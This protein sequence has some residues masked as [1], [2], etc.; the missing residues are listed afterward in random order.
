[1]SPQWLPQNIQKR[2]LL[3]VLQQLSLF[4]EIDLPNLEEVSLNNIHLKDIS[5]DPEK[6]G[7]LP[8]CNLRYGQLGS[9]E[10]NGGVMGGV[11]IEV[12]NLDIVIAPNLDINE[13]ITKSV[14]LSLAQSTA[15]L[16]QTIMLNQSEVL[17]MGSLE[18]TIELQDPTCI[19]PDVAIDTS[20]SDSSKS[21]ASSASSPTIPKPSALGGVMARAVDMALSRLQVSIK[22]VNIKL[23]SELTDIV[24]KVE[25]ATLS[26]VSGT[27]TTHLKGVSVIT[28]RPACSPGDCEASNNESKDSTSGTKEEDSDTSSDDDNDE[29]DSS[30][31]DSMVFTHEEASSIYMSATSQSF[32][33]D[34]TEA[35]PTLCD[36]D[37][38]KSDNVIMY[39]DSLDVEF[40]GLSS[41]S[42]VFVEIEKLTLSCSPLVPT[43][44]SVINGISRSLK[45]KIYQK[46]KSTTSTYQ[47]NPRFPQYASQSDDINETYDKDFEDED[48]KHNGPDS[49]T[50]GD[51]QQ[52]FN[53]LH[54]GE[55]ILSVTSALN[56][57]GEFL[58]PNNNLYLSVQ[59][60]NIKQKHD[61]LIYGGLETFQIIKTTDGKAENVLEFEQSVSEDGEPPKADIRF[62]MFSKISSDFK[63]NEFTALISKPGKV[64]LDSYSLGHIS[65]LVDSFQIINSHLT[66]LFANYENYKRLSNNDIKP[67]VKKNKIDNHLVLQTAHMT[68]HL[69]LSSDCRI[70]VQILPIFVNSLNNE[71]K[72][73]RVIVEHHRDGG[74]DKIASISNIFLSTKAQDFK[75]FISH[76]HLFSR[77][78]NVISSTNVRVSKINVDLSFTLLKHIILSFGTFNGNLKS[79]PKRYNLVSMNSGS[80]YN[81]K[82]LKKRVNVTT[83]STKNT[84]EFNVTFEEANFSLNEINKQFGSLLGRAVNISLFEFNGEHNFVLKGVKLN[85]VSGDLNEKIFY[86]Y[87]ERS[88]TDISEPLVLGQLKKNG[89]TELK[90]QRFVI[91]FYAHWQK[92]FEN[93]NEEIKDDLNTFTKD[94]TEELKKTDVRIQLKDCF[95]GV[96]PNTLICKSY[97][98][99]SRVNC[100]LMLG[101]E[102]L[103][104][105]TTVRELSLLLIDDLKELRSVSINKKYRYS[106]NPLDFFLKRGFLNIGNIANLHIGITYNFNIEKLLE[107]SSNKNIYNKLSALDI[108]VNLDECILETCGD[109]FYTFIQLINDLKIPLVL[110]NEEKFKVNLEHEIN[111]LEG[112]D[113]L[114]RPNPSKIDS[115]IEDQHTDNDKDFEI[116]IDNLSVDNN[117]FS[118]NKSSQKQTVD[119]V[120]ISVNVGKANLYMYDGYD[121]KE[122]RKVI[123]GVVKKVEKE[124]SEA[125]EDHDSNDETVDDHLEII[126]ETLFQSIH[127]TLPKGIDPSQLTQN[128]NKQVTENADDGNTDGTGYKNLKLKRS[129]RYKM[130]IELKSIDVIVNVFTLRSP[131]EEPIPVHK[132]YEVLNEIELVVDLVTIYDNLLNSTWNKYLSYMNSIGEKEIGKN[133]IKFNLTTIRD[134]VSLNFNESILRI[135][136]LPLRLFIDQDTNEFLVRFFN[137]NDKRFKLE[138]L[139]EDIYVKKIEIRNDIKI[140]VDYKPKKLNL[141]GLKNGEFNELLNLIHINGLT[142]NLNHIKLYGIKGGDQ[143]FARLF[144]YW[145]P[146]IQQTQLVNL[147]N[148]VEIFKPFFSISESLK[149]VVLLPITDYHDLNN[150]KFLKKLNKNGKEFF[151]ITS[152]ELLKLGYRLTNGTQNLLEHGEEILGGTGSKLRNHKVRQRKTSAGDTHLKFDNADI[153]SEDET[154]EEAGLLENSIRLNKNTK[155]L[156]S[157]NIYHNP[158]T[159][160]YSEIEEE[161]DDTG[162]SSEEEIEETKLVS[163]YSNQPKNFKQGIQLSFNSINK[164]YNLTKDEF[165]KL[166]E[167][168]NESETYED[169]LKIILKKSPLLLL[170]PMIG[171]TEMISKTLIGL[172][173][174]ISSTEHLESKDKYKE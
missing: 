32:K 121:W 141:I 4:S 57:S 140:K 39:M 11:N 134:P 3:Y 96:T 61:T 118:K 116:G 142:I 97:L 102:Q 69:D 62:E 54:I 17:Q 29:I 7:K 12:N 107:K 20:N 120:S 92:L 66:G 13:D 76:N 150:Q 78:I 162:D 44:L 156:E 126:Q 154:E 18:D 129:N 122:T 9:L 28:L 37:P 104:I 71:M 152:Y 42:N 19:Q 16:A 36:K 55:I 14:Q 10:L 173:N 59:N 73:Q 167:R 91:E 84:A 115:S 83:T 53:R 58:S 85:R 43:V 30:L 130:L 34:R 46:R 99:A 52:L 65:E 22:N 119:P 163:L 144:E 113:E 24:I 90:C 82:K 98:N 164:N 8:G 124:S 81:P 41:I 135:S 70:C 80:V 171:T 127:V 35:T 31:M 1:M 165:L 79:I 111:L 170:R 94:T 159:K 67:N 133:M 169:S 136:I 103:Y 33:P 2:L 139:E 155:R 145:L 86:N 75:T 157:R 74:V 93:P 100:D 26:T 68:M 151:K 38:N 110:K 40:E 48:D 89:S 72:C 114:E 56:L 131:D 109:S 146:N 128:I 117:Y 160:K 101:G 106:V 50:S 63:I 166:I 132:E 153:I 47:S 158:H 6:V 25:E 123:K 87:E 112:I 15:D 137:F 51:Q 168:I 5:I 174:E 125:G 148:G 95:F 143:I 88:L 108:K 138:K 45:L 49:S 27:R 147:F 21:S 105:K 77:D 60:F 149:N 172:S 64:N 23:L 161:A